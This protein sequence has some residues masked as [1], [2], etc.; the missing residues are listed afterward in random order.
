MSAQPRGRGPHHRSQ[1][2]LLTRPSLRGDDPDAS[3]FSRK[4][5]SAPA[6]SGDWSLNNLGLFT[7]IFKICAAAWTQGRR[8]S[9]SPGSHPCS[10]AVPPLPL[11]P[12][13]SRVLKLTPTPTPAQATLSCPAPSRPLLSQN[14]LRSTSPDRLQGRQGP[15][16]VTLSD[17]PVSP[18][19]ATSPSVPSQPG[20]PRS[21]L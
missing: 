1:S 21:S 5:E 9:P 8:P 11:S 10:P 6:A 2:H 19:G 18:P 15:G 20:G 13:A 16:K 17:V 4:G 12:Q 3:F 14:H 7:V